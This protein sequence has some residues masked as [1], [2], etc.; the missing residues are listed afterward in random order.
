MHVEKKLF[1]NDIILFVAVVFV[2]LLVYFVFSF[3]SDSEKNIVEV[4]YD[5]KIIAEISLLQDGEYR[6]NESGYTVEVK[7]G[8]M[9]VSY[10]DCKDKVCTGMFIDEN[11]G[12]IICV[13]NKIV[14][15]RETQ[16]SNHNADVSAG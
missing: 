3:N 12:E 13:P 2:S 5:G 6:I 9:T 1:R 11:G 10:T 7:N 16:S 4:Q 15:R 14:I 8:K